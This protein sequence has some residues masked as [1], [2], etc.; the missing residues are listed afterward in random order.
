M[1]IGSSL[2]PHDHFIR[3]RKVLKKFPASLHDDKC[4]RS[5]NVRDI[6][7]YYKGNHKEVYNQIYIKQRKSENISTKIKNKEMSILPL[8]I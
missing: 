2:K 8:L 5:M 7:H 6:S 4:K 1:E 3:Y